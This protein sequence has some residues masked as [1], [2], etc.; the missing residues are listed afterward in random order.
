MISDRLLRFGA[1]L[2][3]SMCDSEG[4]LK[5]NVQINIDERPCARS[6]RKGTREFDLENKS[7]GQITHILSQ[8]IGQIVDIAVEKE[9][10]I[11]I[12]KL[13]FSSKKSRLREYD[14]RYAK[15]LSQFAYSK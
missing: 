8:A 6:T 2:V 13:D 15:M 4:N 3:F 10:P 12:E 1:E 9:C 5:Q 14:K 7:S 11:V